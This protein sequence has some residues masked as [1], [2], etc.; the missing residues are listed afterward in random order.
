MVALVWTHPLDEGLVI[1]A[2]QNFLHEERILVFGGLEF[3]T[4]EFSFDYLT[5][6][7]IQIAGDQNGR[8][9]GDDLEN[10]RA[11]GRCVSFL[12]RL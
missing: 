10:V 11:P 6:H 7:F 4:V 9:D 2:T 3:F 8:T 5:L 1:L 12:T